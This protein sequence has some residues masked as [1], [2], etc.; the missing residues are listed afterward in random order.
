MTEPF[1]FALLGY[2]LL[3]FLLMGWDKFQAKRKG[4]RIPEKTLLAFT[5][6]GAGLGAF[7]GSRTFRHKTRKSPF[8]VLLP[9][10]A[11]ISLILLGF[12]IFR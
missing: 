11:L 2:N 9:I 6:L 8:P 1:T 10:G 12:S 5:L 3:S 7:I 4:P